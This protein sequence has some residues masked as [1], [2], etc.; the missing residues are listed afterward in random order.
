MEAAIK[1]IRQQLEEKR[2]GLMRRA[3]AIKGHIRHTDG[4]LE[5]D[6]AE[7]ATERENDEVLDALDVA[8]RQEIIQ[9]SAALTRMKAGEYG[10]CMACDELINP[11]RLRA[12]PFATTCVK[13]QSAREKAQAN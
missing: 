6:F 2:E 7:Q 12:L 5:A 8:T 13:C 1:D 4:P 9:I 11:R 10:V 3:E